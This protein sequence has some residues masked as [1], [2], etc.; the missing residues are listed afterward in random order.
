M[1]SLSTELTKTLARGVLVLPDQPGPVPHLAVAAGKDGRL[2]ILDRDDMG[3]LHNP[4]IP[5]NVS[6]GRCWCG[7]SYYQGSDTVGRVVTSGGNMVKTWTINTVL[8]PPSLTL[9]A[10]SPALATTSQD[11]GFF[12][13]VSSNGTNSNTAIIWALGRP[14]GSNNQITL[15]AFNGT[16][17]GSA[18]PQLWSGAAGFWPN[19]GGNSNLVPTV[20]N[21]K[22]Y[23]ATNKQLAIFG[24]TSLPLAMAQLQHPAVAIPNLA[25]TQFWGTIKSIHDSRIMLGL[26]TS[27]LLQVDLSKALAQG[28]AIEPQIGENVAING[29]LNQQGGP[30]GRRHVPRQRTQELGSG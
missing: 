20:A 2:F 1:S 6:I 23:A 25:G 5:A 10:S 9:E 17:S 16:K 24:L 11:L 15:Y 3:K 4:D 13:T 28:T 7:Q 12:T 26:R 22:V 19:S 21:G 27:A 18:L 14:T 29:Q 8:R 30:R